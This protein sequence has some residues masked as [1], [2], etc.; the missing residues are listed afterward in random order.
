MQLLTGQP[1]Q[2]TVVTG[3]TPTLVKPISTSAATIAGSTPVNINVSLAQQKAAAAAIQGTKTTMASAPQ[4]RQIQL[5]QHHQKG[6][7]PLTQKIGAFIGLPTKDWWGE[8][9]KYPLNEVER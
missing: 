3:G 1:V 9:K 4:F 5:L 6:A 2:Q 8:N 7:R